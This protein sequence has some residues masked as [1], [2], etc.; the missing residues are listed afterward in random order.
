MDSSGA[1]ILWRDVLTVLRFLN[2]Q[3][4]FSMASVSTS[5]STH[6]VRPD[7]SRLATLSGCGCWEQAEFTKLLGQDTSSHGSYEKR[8]PL[9]GMEA[10]R[11]RSRLIGLSE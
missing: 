8:G 10:P 9:A 2:V 4:P 7:I 3:A 11:P 1:N 6:C 5:N